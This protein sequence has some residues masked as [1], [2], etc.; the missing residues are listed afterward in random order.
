[1][2]ERGGWAWRGWGKVNLSGIVPETAEFIQRIMIDIDM[3]NNGVHA[4][5]ND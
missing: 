3:E 4:R 1:M 5:D 2:D